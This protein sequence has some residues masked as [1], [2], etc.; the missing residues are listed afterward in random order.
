MSV[1]QAFFSLKTTE[2]KTG[3]L[4][5]ERKKKRHHQAWCPYA[6]YSLIL[7]YLENEEK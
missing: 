2:Q 6:Q 7:A 4:L 3:Q 1:V 5:K